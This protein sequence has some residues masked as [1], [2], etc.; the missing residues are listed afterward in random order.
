MGYAAD[1]FALFDAVHSQDELDQVRQAVQAASQR[2]RAGDEACVAAGVSLADYTRSH[3]ERNP[4]VTPEAVAGEPYMLGN[5]AGLD[6]AFRRAIAHPALWQLA[7][8]LLGVEPEQVVYHFSQV[9]RKLARVGPALSWHRDYPNTYV[10][11][12]ASEF[13]RLVVP[14]AS[15]SAQNGGTGIVCG[16]HQVSDEVARAEDAQTHDG[17]G[18]VYPDF[19]AG[20][21]F[22]LHPKVIHGGGPNRTDVDRDMLVIQLGRAGAPMRSTALGEHLSLCTREALTQ[23]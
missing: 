9:V 11:S 4:G 6:P 15:V 1:G 18:A 3:P 19:A 2:F 7:A 23:S 17:V 14:L 22:A 16:S 10:C 8:R 12:G 21:I 13:L 20:Q 5:L